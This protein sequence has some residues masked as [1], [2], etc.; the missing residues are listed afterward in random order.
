MSQ[1]HFDCFTPLN[2]E[3]IF[4]LNNEENTLRLSRKYLPIA[5]R[6]GYHEEKIGRVAI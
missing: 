4:L 2:P 5:R 3:L 6:R 1:I